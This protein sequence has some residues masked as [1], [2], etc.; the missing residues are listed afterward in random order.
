MAV[1]SSQ[2][3]QALTVRGRGGAWKVIYRARP[4]SWHVRG[5]KNGSQRGGGEMKK[6]E[7][8]RGEGWKLQELFSAALAQSSFH[9]VQFVLLRLV[10]RGDVRFLCDLVHEGH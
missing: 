8:E 2:N 4:L 10:A 9:L 7:R 1:V 5:K 3:K 6:K